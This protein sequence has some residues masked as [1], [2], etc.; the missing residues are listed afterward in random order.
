VHFPLCV[1]KPE[2]PL[3]FRIQTG[4]LRVLDEIIYKYKPEKNSH[5][6][7]EPSNFIRYVFTQNYCAI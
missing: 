5:L 1:R 4:S 3:P 7:N 2:N 6:H